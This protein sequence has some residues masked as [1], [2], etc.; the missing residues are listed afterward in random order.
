MN[1]WHEA[2]EL[3]TKQDF[4]R[5]FVVPSPVPAHHLSL[6]TSTLVIDFGGASVRAGVATR[7]AALPQIFFPST[8]ASERG[9]DM[10]KYFGLDCLA[11]E[12]RSRSIITN[13]MV[14]SIQVDKYSVDQV[15]LQ[16]IFEKIF[17]VT[18]LVN[19]N[20]LL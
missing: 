3:H 19:S 7:V 18:Q 20:I 8:M 13:P 14:P 11:D 2:L 15:A 4:A 6:F 5:T 16:G 10:A 12:V 1:R 17:K 9:N